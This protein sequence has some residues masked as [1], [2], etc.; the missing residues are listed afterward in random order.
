MRY[1][2]EC[3]ARLEDDARY[4]EECGAEQ[5]PF[6]EVETSVTT[7]EDSEYGFC[8]E[9]GARIKFT[10]KFCEGCGTVIGQQESVTQIEEAQKEAVPKSADIKQDANVFVPYS[11][12]RQHPLYLQ[13]LTQ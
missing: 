4:C 6:V 13:S 8:E 11:R 5:E 2:E 10:D 3:G 7:N 9:C 12:L 1:C